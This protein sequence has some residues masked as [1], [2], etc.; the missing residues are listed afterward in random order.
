MELF[1]GWPN[2]RPW[3]FLLNAQV[4]VIAR[5][6]LVLEGGNVIDANAPD[7]SDGK[8]RFGTHVKAADEYFRMMMGAAGIVR[9][10]L[11]IEFRAIRK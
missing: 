4:V 6:D 3:C 7:R 11:Q 8:G 1:V 5:A 2:G 9:T 10:K